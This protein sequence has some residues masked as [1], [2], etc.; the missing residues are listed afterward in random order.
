MSEVL[1]L[2]FPKVFFLIFLILLHAVTFLASSAVV[3]AAFCGASCVVLEF[4]WGGVGS[5]FASS[6][7]ILASPH[8]V[9]PPFFELGVECLFFEAV[10]KRKPYFCQGTVCL[11]PLRFWVAA[12]S[13]PCYCG[14]QSFGLSAIVIKIQGQ[15]CHRLVKRA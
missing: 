5:R 4:P 8:L 13:G 9:D 11:G 10:L 2:G 3:R 7:P 6:S 12:P 15:G 1:V 14:Q